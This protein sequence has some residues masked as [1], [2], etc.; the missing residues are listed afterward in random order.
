M[1]VPPN[2]EILPPIPTDVKHC[3]KPCDACPF[4][5]NV[6]PGELGGSPPETFLGQ[7][8]G[9]FWLPC[10]KHSEYDNPNWK[11]DTSKPQCAGAAV[12]RAN[13]GWDKQMPPSIHHLPRDTA[14]VFASPAEFLS[15]HLRCSMFD[16]VIAL[17]L[18]PVEAMCIREFE[19]ATQ[20]YAAPE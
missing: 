1:N 17:N 4:S 18:V 20:Y 10:H 2:A 8:R 14:T 5:R 12:F 16:A 19:K 6:T 7:A 3:T 9:P 13:C 11:T 15:H